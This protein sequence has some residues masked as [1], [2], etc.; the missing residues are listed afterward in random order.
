MKAKIY[1]KTGDKGQ[2]SL[3]G[4]TRVP[5]THVRI[6]AYGTVDE[7][8]SALGVLRGHIR[9]ADRARLIDGDLYAAL[10]AR[11]QAIQNTLFNIGSHLACESEQVKLMLP[12]LNPEELI[13]LERDMDLWESELP[14]LREFI[15]P[16]GALPA[17]C[18]HVARTICRRAERQVLRSDELQDPS[19]S[20]VESE[21]LMYLNRLSD[22]LFLLGRKLNAASGEEDITWSKS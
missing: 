4:G 7:L 22:W 19:F 9:D 3:V 18:A 17:A 8:N 6:E 14:P 20:R 13:S 1:T 11:L 10:E 21:H 15:L 5:K 2:T 16:G 12:A